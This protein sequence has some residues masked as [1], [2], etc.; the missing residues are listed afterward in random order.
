MLKIDKPFLY[1][2]T[3]GKRWKHEEVAKAALKAGVRIIQYREKEAPARVMV[4]EARRIR[5]LCDEYDAM[6]IVNDRVD[7]AIAC[8]ADGVH[9]GQDDIPAEIVA[10]IFDGIIGM[11]VKTV[12]QA[13]QAE[14]Y[15]DYLGAGSAFPTG[16]KESKVIGVEGIRRIVEAV[17]IPVVAIG[18]ITRENVLEVLKT[19]VAGVAVVSA[20]SMA[21][22][23]EDA[24]RKLLGILSTFNGG[25]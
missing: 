16:T 23:P 9:V 10:E 25:R 15:A 12:E 8:N 21:D 6:L 17:S 22:D 4:G 5:K 14:E 18:G 19:G 24:A 20:V 2:I 13:K 1:V 7:I 3:S 11:S